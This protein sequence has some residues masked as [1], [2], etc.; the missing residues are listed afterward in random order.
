MIF[1]SIRRPTN[2]AQLDAAR[3]SSD[4]VCFVVRRAKT[5]VSDS[6]QILPVHLRSYKLGRISI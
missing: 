2:L 6:G 1:Y 4:V 3:T 5:G